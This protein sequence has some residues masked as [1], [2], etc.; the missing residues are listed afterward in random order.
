MKET[1]HS[2]PLHEAL[3]RI[4]ELKKGSTTDRELFEALNSMY[5]VSY[6]EFLKVLMKLE[7][8]GIIKV[9]T[10]KEGVLI[11]ELL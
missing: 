9:S 3:L 6:P 5:D 1:W 8:N 10:A 4:L 11:V 7:L 2:T